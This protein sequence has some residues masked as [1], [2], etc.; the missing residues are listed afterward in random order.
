MHELYYVCYIKPLD[1]PGV[2]LLLCSAQQPFC[3]AQLTQGH[4]LCRRCCSSMNAR[5]AAC[6]GVKPAPAC[7]CFG[8]T[9][10]AEI[11]GWGWLCC[12]C[13]DVEL[14]LT[15]CC[16]T[17]GSKVCWPVIPEAAPML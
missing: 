1:Y 16:C 5:C 11:G 13:C 14:A 12:C 10:V 15:S 2:W 3:F 6:N 9:E 17:G 4:T 8:G 7:P